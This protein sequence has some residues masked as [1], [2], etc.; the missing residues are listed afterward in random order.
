MAGETAMSATD[1]RVVVNAHLS[2]VTARERLDGLQWPQE[3]R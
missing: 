1:V 2:G 3:R